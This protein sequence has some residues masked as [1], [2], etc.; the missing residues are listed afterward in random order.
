MKLVDVNVLLYVVNRD[1][2]HHQTAYKWWTRL[3]AGD[4]GVGLTWGV[5]QSFL[6]LV[7]HQRV[8]ARPQSPEAAAAILDR[9]LEHPSVALIEET[10]AHWPLLRELLTD[11]NLRGDIIADANLA[12]L[13]IYHRASLASFDGDFARFPQLAWEVPAS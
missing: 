5:A 6:R 2:P 8:L 4:E 1:S 9:W 11:L 7:T 12:A 13:A 3:L 10:R